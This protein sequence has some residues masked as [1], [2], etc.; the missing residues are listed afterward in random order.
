MAPRSKAQSFRQHPFADLDRILSKKA[1]RLAESR[2]WIQQIQRPPEPLSAAE[3]HQLFK[4]A[5]TGVRPLRANRH[6]D[7]PA[8]PECSQVADN[9][10]PDGLR[11]LRE[12]VEE[13]KGFTLAH[14]AEYMAGPGAGSTNPLIE[15]LHQGRFTIQD[16]IDLHGMGVPEAET[17]FNHFF[18]R[19]I[20]TGLRG[21][22]V[23]HGRGLRSTAAPVLK[24]CVKKWLTRGRWRR[25][26][27]AF[28]S[29]Q[30]VD[31]G[32]GA[33]YVLLRNTPQRRRR[34]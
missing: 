34:S 4:R 32:T 7:T 22:L 5:M 18:K 31:G 25:W 30:A 8:A 19:A 28:A 2:A 13:G 14:T 15:A 17:A 12:L 33:T 1:I 11:Q 29:A 21:V 9:T 23:V 20:A 27:V 24:R 10:E 26:V 3:E 6:T 16:H